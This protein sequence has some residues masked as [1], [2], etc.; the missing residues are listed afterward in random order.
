VTLQVEEQTKDAK[1]VVFKKKRR[2]GYKRKEGFRREVTILRV[3]GIDAT[4]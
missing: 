3:V 2:K 1:V 4:P